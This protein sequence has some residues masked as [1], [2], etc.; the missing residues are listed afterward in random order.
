MNRSVLRLLDI[1]IIIA[2]FS[3]LFILIEPQYG[4][5]KIATKERELHSNMFTVKAAIERYR[6]FNGG[7]IPFSLED[8]YNNI[9]ALKV[10]ENPY[11]KT[12]MTMYDLSKFLY[13]VPSQTESVDTNGYHSEKSGNPGEIS[14]GY[15]VTTPE[16]K[17]TVARKFALIS[18]DD[19]GKPLTMKE[20]EKVRII[21]LE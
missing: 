4:Q 20:G 2:F 8:I 10:P 14:V 3:L 5:I 18:F 11:T 9:E 12:K 19:K 13:D 16:K 6:A 17:D 7:E 15:Y 1:L 21:V